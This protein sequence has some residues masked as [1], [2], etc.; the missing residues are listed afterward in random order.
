M[1]SNFLISTGARAGKTMVGCALAF[2][3]KVRG[4]RVGVMKP[5]QAGAVDHAGSL[6]SEDAAILIAAAS[7][8]L[9]LELVCAYRYRSAMPPAAAAQVDGAGAPDLAEIERAYREIAA[10]ADVVLVEDSDG[11]AASIDRHHT[12]GDLARSLGLEIILVV[13]NRPG[14]INAAAMILD[15]AARRALPV[16]GFIVN[17]LDRDASATAQRDAEL[18]VHATGAI[19]LGTVR[20]KEPLSFAI[21]E[22]ILR[23]DRSAD[24]N[25]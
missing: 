18:I 21:V 25:T 16:R 10:S 23:A 17:A 20:F 6:V 11:L 22:R 14:F 8:D 3:F 9:P 12:F 2:A 13:A 15:Y 1:A 24:G 7:S 19:S 5:V 4:M